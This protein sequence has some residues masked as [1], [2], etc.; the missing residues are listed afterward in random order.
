MPWVVTHLPWVT[1]I[2]SH[3]LERAKKHFAAWVCIY[4]GVCGCCLPTTTTLGASLHR[5]G[6]CGRISRD[7]VSVSFFTNKTGRAPLL[8][9]VFLSPSR[10]I[11]SRRT[12]RRKCP[13]MSPFLNA[14]RYPHPVITVSA[15]TRGGTPPAFAHLKR[16]VGSS[17]CTNKYSINT[18]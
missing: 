6:M 15:S 2:T 4:V 13:C 1:P 17:S 5:F 18:K 14:A 7:H 12:T 16:T 3:P 11:A 9:A 8:R 10:I